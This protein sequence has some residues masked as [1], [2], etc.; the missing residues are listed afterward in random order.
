MLN[1]TREI[2]LEDVPDPKVVQPT[3]AVVRV[4]ASCVCGS[5]LWPY[6]GIN[7]IDEPQ[8]IGH[9]FVGVVEELGSKVSTVR[10]GDFVISPF[11]YSDNTCPHCQAGFHTACAHRWHLGRQRPRR[12]HG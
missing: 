6:R 8:R 4:V 7:E 9:E 12:A 2:A 1:A 3:D 10:V 11:T 5:D